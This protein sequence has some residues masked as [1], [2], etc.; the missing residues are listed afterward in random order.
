MSTDLP[1]RETQITKK[2][3][4]E[5][6]HLFFSGLE[7]Q[8][9][10][11]VEEKFGDEKHYGKFISMG[12]MMNQQRSLQRYTFENY[13]ADSE[14]SKEDEIRL[15]GAIGIDVVEERKVCEE[16][17]VVLI[18]ASKQIKIKRKYKNG[19]VKKQIL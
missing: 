5:V 10:Q 1:K 18:V 6:R 14:L 12:F 13:S 19:E 2:E 11:G 9:Y 16:I 8:T 7:E 17:F 4:D 3:F 15:G